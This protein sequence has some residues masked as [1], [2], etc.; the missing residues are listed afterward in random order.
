MAKCNL[1]IDLQ[2]PDTIFVG[3]ETVRGTVTVQAD[4]NVRCNGLTVRSK[5]T[6]NGRGNIASE[7]GEEKTLFDGEWLGGQTYRYDFE[8]QTA[9]WPPTYHGHYL[10]VDHTIE[11]QADIPWSFDPKA[12]QVIRVTATKL[13]SA[14]ELSEQVTKLK[15]LPLIGCGA[16]GMLFVFVFFFAVVVNPFAWIL[17]GIVGIISGIWWFIFRFLPK[18][19]LGNVE[20][21]LQTQTLSPGEELIGE[22]V[23]HPKR[24]IP[25]NQIKWQVQAEEVCVSGSGS[26]RRTHRHTLLDQSVPLMQNQTLPGNRETRIPLRITLPADPFYSLDLRDNDL[27]W[28]TNIRIDIPRWPDWKGSER[29]TVVPQSGST[30][31]AISTSMPTGG[32]AVDTSRAAAAMVMGTPVSQ[33]T[34]SPP[35]VSFSETMRVLWE[36]RNDR[37]QTDRLI[38]A[39]QG[40]RF[41]LELII[42]RRLL[43]GVDDPAAYR[44]GHV[45][46]AHYPDPE[47]PITL[48]APSHLGAEFEQLGD[49]PWQGYGEITGFDRR[50]GRLKIHLE[51]APP[52]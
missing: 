48:Y 8:V 43:Y 5:W 15:G 31:A 25:I 30:P 11:A 3:G 28:K 17:G 16:I 6:T 24:D 26:N 1:S 4:S 35:E 14:E 9:K 29:F 38:E 52:A 13:P 45:I 2:N 21:K 47:L 49:K 27:C 37:M 12:D 41:Q 44:N 42:E 39:V 36:A 23:V 20:Y 32:F 46:W 22:L 34:S 7:V 10:N 40:I 33:P 50:Y 51:D 18:A 19:R